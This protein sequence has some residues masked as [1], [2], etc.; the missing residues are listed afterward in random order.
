[1]NPRDLLAGLHSGEL[2]VT[3]VDAIYDSI[4]DSREA[5]DVQRLLVLSSAEWKAFCFGVPFSRLADWRYAEWPA[6]CA[7]CDRSVAIEQ[8]DW[9]V[10]WHGGE[11]RLKHLE[12]PRGPA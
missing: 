10:V 4:M 12:C 7:V 1:M 5:S 8:S 11:P 3:D 6:S 9:M 2:T